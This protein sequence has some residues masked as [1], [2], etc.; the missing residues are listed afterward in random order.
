MCI[1]SVNFS[2]GGVS[3]Q[4]SRAVS[5]SCRVEIFIENHVSQ[6]LHLVFCKTKLIS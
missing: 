4:N 6:A 2:R 1:K 5:L 3:I